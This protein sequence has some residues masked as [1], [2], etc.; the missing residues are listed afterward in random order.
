MHDSGASGLA[1]HV[2]RLNEA[3]AAEW[4]RAA[5]RGDF[6]EAWRCSD[7]I[8]ART[9]NRGD[10]AVP[11]H[12]QQIWDGTPL[13]GRRVLVRCYHGLGD[14]IQFA[15][16][17]PALR[18]IARDVIVW[19][20]PKLVPLLQT[21]S[22]GLT[23]L[24]L[25]DGAPDVEYDVDIEIMELAYAFRT[26]LATIPANVP[27]LRAPAA[28][29]AQG[30]HSR[31]CAVGI[32][33]RAG[34]WNPERSIDFTLLTSFL[35]DIG[36]DIRW[37]SLQFE[38]RAGESHPR[39][40]PCAAEDSDINAIAARMQSLSLVISIDSMPAH[41]AG[42]LG[43][44]VW[45]LL[46]HEADWRWLERRGDSPWYPTMRLFRQTQPGHWDRV[47]QDV[48]QALGQQFNP[49]AGHARHGHLPCFQ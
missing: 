30:E 38:A 48:H 13:E 23:V 16:Y 33:W 18:I 35:D 24:P 47:L 49:E 32:A 44:P 21:V 19:A 1:S 14:T 3:D 46:P 45:T 34:D 43:V 12:L 39:L 27:Y 36:L 22:D 11:R 29:V 15:R 17:L 37:H 28:A 31:A 10:P 8:R 25:H 7:R 4:M 41:L 9:T 42:A 40:Q 26:T 6:E 5:R 2:E 20:Q